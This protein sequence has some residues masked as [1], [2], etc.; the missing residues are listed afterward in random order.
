MK[1]RWTW[2]SLFV[3]ASVAAVLVISTAA[4][5]SQPAAKKAVL[6]STLKI[7]QPVTVREK[8]QL[9]E[10]TVMD[11]DTGTHTVVEIGEDYI[12]LRDVAEVEESRI[13]I[14]AIRV[15]V[16]IKAKPK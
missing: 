8:G 14:Y 5:Q 12:V 11:G 16:H 7:G 9:F 6:F 15:V 3:I 1:T 10:I 13:P 2:T 4:S